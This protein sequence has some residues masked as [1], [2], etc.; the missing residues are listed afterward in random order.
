MSFAA[1]GGFIDALPMDPSLVL[2]AIDAGVRL[3]LKC[4][5]VLLDETVEKPLLLPV[6]NLYGDIAVAQA[7]QFFLLAENSALIDPGGPYEHCDGNERLLAYKTIRSLNERLGQDPGQTA[8]A[9]QV[10]SQLHRYEQFRKGFGARSPVQRI[11]G[12]VVQIGIEYFAAHPE[13]LGRDSNQRRI[14]SS[15]VGG[16]RETD[17]AEGTRA[18]IVGHLLQSALKTLQQHVTLVDDDR[19]VQALLGGVCAALLQ[20]V[21]GAPSIADKVHREQL[22]RRI[23]SSI[24]RGGATAF[25][26][27]S[28]LFLA[29]NEAGR[30]MVNSTLKQLL[31]GVRGQEDLFTNETFEKLFHCALTAVGENAALLTNKVVLQEILQTSAQAL[32][33][34]S[35]RRLFTDGAVARVLLQALQVAAK[36]APEWMGNDPRGQQL[37]GMTLSAFSA[38]MSL[39]PA[40]TRPLRSLLTREALVQ[41]TGELLE[42]VAAHPELC[43][44]A[45]STAAE[46]TLLAQV[47]GSL[48]EALSVA[49][50]DQV[51]SA[52]AAGLVRVVVTAALASPSGLIDPARADPKDQPLTQVL[53]QIVRGVGA[54]DS[55]R[56]LVTAVV[57]LD[58]VDGILPTVTAN[59]AGLASGGDKP[60]ERI[61]RGVLDLAD[62]PLA[63][64]IDRT[65][66][67]RL[68]AGLV[69]AALW[70]QLDPADAT[71]LQAAAVTYLKPRA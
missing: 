11:L 59:L 12:T 48:A 9:C 28:G 68:A 1:G 67:P 25:V 10:I 61:L 60:I 36:H 56:N 40:S 43:G 69:H 6:G 39:D 38:G 4:Y 20:D 51:S 47:I 7:A 5:E 37:A 19:R 41:L 49:D 30:A 62:G 24:L 70:D 3:G 18:E 31:E 15:F 50:P 33:T 14:V 34:T 23:A 44:E 13:A 26:E 21:E 42:L 66:F 63:G 8:D 35:G 2:F 54:K 71:A 64:R 58:L 17:F 55:K 22:A 46:R 57:F 29:G 27:Q 52:T 53:L 65:N 16:L 32:G 45:D